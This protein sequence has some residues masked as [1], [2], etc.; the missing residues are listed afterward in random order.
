MKSLTQ[1]DCNDLSIN[2]EQM[3]NIKTNI[4]PSRIFS[5][6]IDES[7]VVRGTVSFLFTNSILSSSPPLA[8]IMLLPT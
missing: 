1:S 5:I 2:K 3:N 8:G 4:M 7:N 6:T